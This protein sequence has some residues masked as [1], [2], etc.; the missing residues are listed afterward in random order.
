[1]HI[2]NLTRYLKN[3]IL[4]VQDY[5]CYI[6]KKYI[7]AS[8]INVATTIKMTWYCHGKVGTHELH[9]SWGRFAVLDV[10]SMAQNIPGECWRVIDA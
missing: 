8:P 3:I 7:N 5:N 1:M 4:G 2:K 9:Q 10:D 6:A